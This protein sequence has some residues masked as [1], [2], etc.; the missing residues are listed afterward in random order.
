MSQRPISLSADLRRL[1]NEG[2]DLE[3]R[4]GYL[5][6]KGVPYV[7]SAREIKRGTL[8]AKLVLA[9]DETVR[10]DDHVAH[11]A[12]EYPCR[13]DGK[14]IERI[15]N[16]SQE[17]ALAEGVVIQHTFS[18]KPKPQGFYE[19]YHAK[20]TAY[21]SILSGPAQAIDPTVTAK[22]FPLIGPEENSDEPFNYIDTASSRAEINVVARKLALQN[23]AIIGL[24]GT[25]S[26]VLDL[27]AKTPV[28]NIHLFDGDTFLQHNAFRSP[29]A[30]SGEDLKARQP[31]TTYFHG[32]YSRMHKGIVDHAAYA[33]ESNIEALRGMDFLFLC[34]DHGPA[35]KF[36]VERLESFNLSFIDVGMGIQVT[37]DALGG[38]LRVTMSTPEKRDHLRTRVSF[39]EGDG[40]NEYDRNIQVADL[41]AL[42]AALAVIKWKKRYGFYRDVKREHNNQFT[43]D[44][45]FLLNED[46]ES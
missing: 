45:N 24:G 17:R 29:G 26:Y 39:G 38:I 30:P 3:V 9:N 23:V 8:V 31:K 36:V 25:G 4:S 22:T 2:Y 18:A 10:P 35:K 20:I 32:I 7:N 42:N 40:H 15:R 1:R 34:L 14:A 41:N 6:V 33:D 28:R 46:L 43:T 13:G 19:D 21:V 16:S 44:G 12:G 27:V 11:F 37:D 5:L